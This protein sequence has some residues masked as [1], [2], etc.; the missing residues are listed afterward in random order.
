MEAAAI[1]GSQEYRPRLEAFL[2]DAAQ[3]PDKYGHQPRLYAL[4]RLC[5]AGQRYDDEIVY[6]AAFLHDLG[7]FVGRRPENPELLAQWDHVRHAVDHAPAILRECGFLEERVPAVLRAI[8][9]HQPVDEP[10]SIEAVILRD[11]DILEQLGAIGILRAAAKTGRDT[12]YPTFTPVVRFLERN[13]ATLPG[14]I[15][16]DAT[17]ALAGPKIALLR[18]FLDAVA[19][20]DQGFLL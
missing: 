15:R 10:A 6:A 9:T 8:E 19:A 18:A 16:L 17:R 2:R 1:P 4:T 14:A 13:L 3:P 20:E 5:G 12:R 11:A 7:V